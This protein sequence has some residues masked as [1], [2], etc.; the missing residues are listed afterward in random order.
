M[1]KIYKVLWNSSRNG[2]VVVDEA[3]HAHE[4]CFSSASGCSPSTHHHSLKL[5]IETLLAVSAFSI[6]GGLEAAGSEITSVQSWGTT[7]STNGNVHEI[8]TNKIVN[9]VVGVN[10]FEKFK[11]SKGDI[12]NLRFPDGTGHLVNFVDDKTVGIEING[13][14]NGVKGGKIDGDLY[15]VSPKGFVVGAT[16]VVNAKGLTVV[17]PTETEY[18]LI[19]GDV[20]GR[21][22][23]AG[24]NLLRK[25]QKA[26]GTNLPLNPHGV[27]TVQG[28][29]NAGNNLTLAAANISIPKD[30]VVQAG[31]TDFSDYVN[32]KDGS[33][34]KVNSGLD[35]QNLKLTEV[36]G[37]VVL[38]ASAETNLSDWNP[39]DI[40]ASEHS[41]R[42]AHITIGGEVSSKGKTG[43]VK[44]AAKA[45]NNDNLLGNISAKVKL[46]TGGKITASGDVSV[47][48]DASTNLKSNG[49][50]SGVTEYLFDFLGGQINLPLP[51]VAYSNLKTSALVD[52]D[53]G[54]VISA[55]KDV[56]LT[57]KATVK[58]KIGI[59]AADKGIYQS[60]ISEVVDQF[61]QTASVIGFSTQSSAVN[62]KGSISAG[63]D[64]SILS[65]GKFNLDLSAKGNSNK[66]SVAAT[67]FIYSDTSANSSVTVADTAILDLGSS[68]S[69]LDIQS[70]QT[71][72]VSTDS[73]VTYKSEKSATYGGIAFNYSVFNSASNV[74]LN[75]SP[76]VNGQEAA[77]K[78]INLSSDNTTSSW[79]VNSAVDSKWTWASTALVG[80]ADSAFKLEVMNK[81]LG[82]TNK[83]LV[84]ATAQEN[85]RG[86]VATT[87]ALGSQT[88]NV[89]VGNGVKLHSS[90]GI[91]LS[92]NAV[93]SDYVFSA[94][95]QS[96]ATEK[97]TKGL[98]AVSVVV[99]KP[100]FTD[101]N[102]ST[103]DSQV[104]IGE[105]VSLIADGKSYR[106]TVKEDEKEV[107]GEEK[108]G[109]RLQSSS[110]MEWDRFNSL[111]DELN[112]SWDIL[113]KQF[114]EKNDIYQK[115]LAFKTDT[116]TIRQN[117]AQVSGD[118][119]LSAW[120]KTKK[121]SES[122]KGML[123]YVKDLEGVYKAI[124]DIP[125]LT[126][127]TSLLESALAFIGAENYANIKSYAATIAPSTDG[128]S[129]AFDLALSAAYAQQRTASS[130]IVGNGTVIETKG[131]S[132]LALDSSSDN[133]QVGITGRLTTEFVNWID[134]NT[135]SKSIG[136]SVLIPVLETK[137]EIHLN[138][139][140]QIISDGDL[141]INAKDKVTAVSIA[142]GG[143]DTDNVLAINGMAV[144]SSVDASNRIVIDPGALLQ[145]NNIHIE[146]SRK[147]SI[148]TVAGAYSGSG[149]AAF[150]IGAAINM[151]G[152]VNE[153]QI[154]SKEEGKEKVKLVAAEGEDGL[155]VL[156]FSD[157][158]VNAVG[159][160]GALSTTNPSREETSGL[161]SILTTGGRSL[162]TVVNEKITS[163][164]AKKFAE[165]GKT[166]A[167]KLTHSQD[168]ASN[169]A[170]Q[171]ASN[172][173]AGLQNNGQ[174]L[175]QNQNQAQVNNQ[176]QQ[177][178][179]QFDL[180]GSVAWNDFRLANT[181]E[182]SSVILDS[183]KVSITAHDDKWIGAWAGAAALSIGKSDK[184]SHSVGIGGA[185]GVNQ[186]N[187]SNSVLL[188]N[189]EIKVGKTS[190]SARSKGTITAEGLALAVA[191]GGQ[192][193]SEVFDGSV[194]VNMI[195]QTT[196]VDADNIVL[197][198]DSSDAPDYEQTAWNGVTQVTG[199][200]SAGFSSSEGTSLAGGFSVAI[201]EI[202]NNVVSKL[203]NAKFESAGD[204]KIA[205]LVS[206][207]QITH[208]FTGQLAVGGDSTYAF[209]GAAGVGQLNNSV[210]AG[211][212]NSTI[213]G[214]SLKVESR[215]AENEEAKKLAQQGPE[216]SNASNA[217]SDYLEEQGIQREE[218]KSS[219][220]QAQE[221]L[222]DLKS[223]SGMTVKVGQEEGKTNE[224]GSV[225]T[226]KP[227]V[228]V[229]VG[230]DIGIGG[231]SGAA[232][233]VVNTI[234]N[235]YS[236]LMSGNTLTLSGG[237][238]AGAV[239]NVTSVGVAAGAAGGKGSFNAAGQVVVSNVTQNA[240]TTINNNVQISAGTVSL[241]SKNKAT[242][243]NVAGNAGLNFGEGVGLGAAVLVMNTNNTADILFKN[244]NKFSASALNAV[245]ANTSSSW[246]AA[247][248][249]S[250]TTGS[251]AIAGAVAVNRVRNTAR[252]TGETLK[253]SSLNS[254]TFDASDESVLWTLSGA[255]GGSAGT[256][257]IGGAV[258][259]AGFGQYGENGTIVRLNT[260]ELE[261][262][263]NSSST[264]LSI[265][266]QGKE[267]LNSL[268]LGV[269]VAAGTVGL[270]GA[271]SV[272][273]SSGKVQAV[274]DNLRGST[275][276]S[277][278]VQSKHDASLGNLSISAS[279][280]GTGA[281]GAGIAI[282]RIKNW[283]T[284]SSV[285]NAG[286]L[287]S[288]LTLNA[289]SISA[290]EHLAI[291]AIGVGGSG[292][293][294]GAL[295][296]S[297]SLNQINS[298]VSAG[299]FNSN[300]NSSSVALIEAVRDTD[301]ETYNVQGAGAGT[302]SGA[303]GVTYSEIKGNS[304]ADV[305]NS[306][307]K[308]ENGSTTR[309]SYS[310]KDAIENEEIVHGLLSKISA[311]DLGVQRKASELSGLAVH[312]DSTQ[313]FKTIFAAGSGSG[314]A[315]LTGTGSGITSQSNSAVNIEGS[316]LSSVKKA[317]VYAGNDSNV[318]AL[319]L[320]GS[321]AAT[322][323]AAATV[324]VLSF[325]NKASVGIKNS[326]MTGESMNIA[327]RVREGNSL[328]GIQ[329]AGATAAAGAVSVMVVRENS[330]SSVAVENSTLT[331][332]N[333][334]L[335][336]S[337]D[338][339]SFSAILGVSGA[340]AQGFG[341]AGDVYWVRGRN[342]SNLAISQGSVLNA[343]KNLEIKA[344]AEG[345]V[346]S[347]NVD[348]AGAEFAALAAGVT[349]TDLKTEASVSV[350]NSEATSVED[351]SITAETSNTTNLTRADAS[352]ALAA[353]GAAVVVENLNGNARVL[354]DHSQ[355]KA[356]KNLTIKALDDRS[357]N[358]GLG[359]GSGGLGVGTAAVFV[360][361]HGS[362]TPDF[363][364][365]ESARKRYE[366][367]KS[368]Y[369]DNIG[370]NGTLDFIQNAFNASNLG[371]AHISDSESDSIK[372]SL[373]S[374][375]KNI[376][377]Q[378][379]ASISV[380]SS[381]LSGQNIDLSAL[382]DSKEQSGTQ[383]IVGGIA[384][385]GITLG[386]S[387]G[388]IRDHNYAGISVTDSTLHATDTLKIKSE[389]DTKN[390]LKVFQGSGGVISAAAT[391]A[392]A[393]LDGQ[394]LIN[395]SGGAL[396]AS[397]TVASTVLNNSQTELESW[398]VQAGGITGGASIAYITDSTGL[399]SRIQ[400]AEIDALNANIQTIAARKLSAKAIA[401]YGGGV[402][403]VGSDSKITIAKPTGSALSSLLNLSGSI[404]NAQNLTVLNDEHS[405]FAV[406]SSGYGGTGIAIGVSL[407]KIEDSSALSTVVERNTINEASQVKVMTAA[408]KD[409]DEEAAS[410]DN[411]LKFSAEAV[412][413]G[414]AAVQSLNNSA[415]VVNTTSVSTTFQGNK[416]VPAEDAKT[417][418][419][420]TLQ[421]LSQA[422][423]NYEVKSLAG[424]GGAIAVGSGVSE[425]THGV[426]V[427]TTVSESVGTKLQDLNI[428]A[429]NEENVKGISESAGG[430]VLLIEG[431]GKS[432]DAARVVHTDKSDTQVSVNGNWQAADE[433]SIF[434][435][436]HHNLRFK[437]DNTKGAL[438]GG[439]GAAVVN[440]LSGISSVTVGDN[441][442]L[443]AGSDIW[444][445]AE[446]YLDIAATDGAYIVDSGVHGAFAGS[447]IHIDTDYNHSNSVVIGAGSQI[448]AAEVIRLQSYT[449]INADLK[450]LADSYGA[451]TGAT[452]AGNHKFTLNNTVDL[453]E[454]SSLKTTGISSEIV[455]S[456]SS[457]E[458]LH[459]ESIGKVAGALSGSG[460]SVNANVARTEL[461]TIGQGA[462]LDS[463]G[464]VR[465][466][467]GKDA[468]GSENKLDL[469][470][471]SHAYAY[472]AL[473]AASTKVEG[474]YV[475]TNKINV[476]GNVYAAR[477]IDAFASEGIV[478]S[479]ESAR[480]W[481]WTGTNQGDIKVATTEAG[482][483]LPDSFTLDNQI[484]VAGS[485][486]AGKNV[487][488]DI[489]ISGVVKKESDAFQ[490]LLNGAPVTSLVKPEITITG[491]GPE[492]ID[493]GFEQYSN[494]YWNRYAELQALIA[495]Y[496]STDSTA[497][498]AYT[499]EAQA[500]LQQ[501]LDKGFFEEKDGE[502]IPVASSEVGI[503][504]LAGLSISGGNVNLKSSHVVGNGT[505]AARGAKHINIENKSNLLLELQDIQI[506]D[507]GGVITYNN[508]TNADV[509]LPEFKGTKEYST[510][511]QAPEFRVTTSFNGKLQAQ[512]EILSEDTQSKTIHT[513]EVP[514]YSDVRIYGK[515]QNLSG[516]LSINSGGDI[517]VDA[518]SVVNAAGQVNLQATGNVTQSY[519]EG[520][521]SVGGSV[522]E[523]W[524]D[525]WET[526]KKTG[527][528]QSSA[529]EKPHS[530]SAGIHA[531]GDIFIAADMINVNGTVQSGYASYDLTLD[532]TS[533]KRISEIRD[534]W[535][536]QG[537]PDSIN[538]Y[539]DQYL[540]T[541]GLDFV[542]S[543]GNW[544]KNCKAWY[545]PVTDQIVL[546]DIS[547]KGGRIYLTGKIAN[548]GGGKLRA[549][550]GSVGIDINSGTHSILTGDINTGNLHGSIRIT[551]T[552]W[553]G[554]NKNGETVAAKVT[555]YSKSQGN[556]EYWLYKSG[557]TSEATAIAEGAYNPHE[558][559][560]YM[561]SD[562]A[563]ETKVKIEST[564][565]RFHIWGAWKKSSLSWTTEKEPTIKEL[566]ELKKGGT[567]GVLNAY[568]SG[569]NIFESWVTKY[570][571]YSN[572]SV[573]DWVEYDN[574]THFNGYYKARRTTKSGDLVVRQYA[575]KAD[576]PID[577]GFITTGQNSINLASSKNVSIGGILN[578]DGGTIT[579]NAGN[580]I[581]SDNARAQLSGAKEINLTAAGNIGSE[582]NAIKLT[583]KNDM[584]VRAVGDDIS[585]NASQVQGTLAGSIVGRGDVQ[586]LAQNT[587]NL[588]RFASQDAKLTSE[589]G[590]VNIHEL[591]QIPK[592]D[593][594]SRLDVNANKGQVSIT[595]KGD[596]GLGI[597]KA[598]KV[599]I[600]TDGA[601]L[602][603]LPRE[604]ADQVSLEEK[605][606][607]WK[608]AGILGSANSASEEAL[609]KAIVERITQQMKG[610]FERYAE[611]VEAE[612]ST[613]SAAQK[614]YRDSLGKKLSD[615]Y[616]RSGKKGED[617]K[618]DIEE[619]FKKYISAAE[620]NP[621]SELAR[622]KAPSYK[623]WTESELIYAVSDVITNPKA[624]DT[625]VLD[626]VANI[627]ADTV[628]LKAKS[629][630]QEV[631]P[632][633][634][635][636]S[637]LGG[638]QALNV[639]K[640]LAS[641]DAHDVKWDA[642]QGQ[643]TVGLKR[644]ISVEASNLTESL[645]K[646]HLDA[647]TTEGNVFVEAEDNSA[648]YV[649]KVISD[650]ANYEVRLSA[651]QGIYN[652]E[653]L[654]RSADSSLIKSSRVTLRGGIGSLGT[655]VARLNIELINPNDLNAYGSF[656]ASSGV[657]LNA[658]DGVSTNP[659]RVDAIASDKIVDISLN[660][661][662][663][664]MT[665]PSG[666]ESIASSYI[667]AQ[668]I[669]L[670]D[671]SKV[672]SDDNSIRLHSEKD[673][674]A[675]LTFVTDE[676][677]PVQPALLNIHDTGSGTLDVASAEGEYVGGSEEQSKRNGNLSLNG[678]IKL[679]G[680]GSVVS[681]N[682]ESKSGNVQVKVAN[683]AAVGNVSANNVELA[684]S[685]GAITAKEL[686]A[687]EGAV[688]ATAG[689]TLTTENVV[690]ANEANLTAMSTAQVGNVT[691][692]KSI[693][694]ASTDGS[695]TAGA[696]T[697]EEGSITAT[698]G[699]TLTTTGKVQSADLA[700]LTANDAVK[701]SDVRAKEIQLTSTKAD[702]TA[703]DLTST[704]G[705]IT[706]KSGTELKTGAL[707]SQGGSIIA[708]AGTSLTTTGKVNSAEAVT[709]TA[710]NDVVMDAAEAEGV[711]SVSSTSGNV[712]I[713]GNLVSN[714]GSIGISGAQKVQAADLHASK[715][716]GVTSETNGI[717]LG[718]LTSDTAGVTLNA[719]LFVKSQS[720][721]A[722][723]GKLGIGTGGELTLPAVTADSVD[724]KAKKVISKDNS[725]INIETR[726]DISVKAETIEAESVVLKSRE[727]NVTTT[728]FTENSSAKI[729][730]QKT[731]DI[732]A[733]KNAK[734]DLD[735][736]IDLTEDFKI[737]A[738]KIEG[739]QE[740]STISAGSVSIA[741]RSG[742]LALGT[743]KAN[744]SNVDVSLGSGNLSH[745]GTI[746]AEKGN[747]TLTASLNTFKDSNVSGNA[748]TI[749]G[750]VK[751]DSLNVKSTGQT[752]FGT[753]ALDMD[754]ALVVDAESISGLEKVEVTAGTIALT[755]EKD[756]ELNKLTAE[757]SSVL[758]NAKAANVVF[759]SDL[760]AK[761]G[762]TVNA[763]AVKMKDA[764][765]EINAGSNIDIKAQTLTA[766]GSLLL[767]STAGS[768]DMNV[769]QK[770]EVE[771][772]LTVKGQSGAT[773][774]ATALEAQSTF[775]GSDSGTALLKTNTLTSDS[776]NMT[777]TEGD[778]GFKVLS[779]EAKPNITIADSIDLKSGK[780]L[781]V[782]AL[783]QYDNLKLNK[784]L[785]L[786]AEKGELTGLNSSSTLT[787]DAGNV[788]ILAKTGA[789]TIAKVQA[790]GTVNVAVEELSIGEV[791]AK[792]KITLAGTKKVS[793]GQIT[794]TGDANGDILVK[795]S[796]GEVLA[797][798]T[799]QSKSGGV[800][801]VGKEK[802]E[803]TT[804]EASKDVSVTSDNNGIIVQKI[805]S[806]NGA[807]SLDSL[808]FI[809][810][811][812]ISAAQKASIT[813]E[814]S[815][816]LPS[817]EA[818][819]AY[820]KA[821]DISADHSV[822]IKTKGDIDV[823][824][825]SIHSKSIKL[826][827][828][829]G[830][831]SIEAADNWIVDGNVNISASGENA[832]V[833]VGSQK[834]FSVTGGAFNINTPNGAA[835]VYGNKGLTIDHDLAI[836]AGKDTTLF[837]ESGDLDIGS[838]SQI[839]AISTSGISKLNVQ[840]GGNLSIG[841]SA[842]L[843][844]NVINVSAQKDVS[845]GS[846]AF[847]HS[848]VDSNSPTESG[849][850]DIKSHTGN[851]TIADRFEI[852]ADNLTTITA[853]QGSVRI[854]NDADVYVSGDLSIKSGEDFV[855]GDDAFIATEKSSVI[856]DE[857]GRAKG[858]SDV[859]IVSG[860]N[861][862]FGEGAWIISEADISVVGGK[863]VK[864]GDEALLVAL[865]PSAEPT[866]G[867][868]T[869]RSTGGSV[870]LEGTAIIYGEE[871]VD[872]DAADK[873]TIGGDAYLASE[874]NVDVYAGEIH[875]D[876]TSEVLTTDGSVN[877]VSTGGII[878]ASDAS[879]K[880]PAGVSI[881]AAGRLVAQGTTEISS[882]KNV[883][884][885]GGEIR[886][887]GTSEIL[888]GNGSVEILSMGDLTL[889][890][891]AS[892]KGE[893]GVSISAEGRF[894][895][896]GTTEISSK[897]KVYIQGG[898][899]RVDGASEVVSEN[900][901]VRLKSLGDMTLAA[902]ASVKA[903]QEVVLLAD[904]NLVAQ[905]STKISS[906]NY[907][908]IAGGNLRFDSAS[909]VFSEN[910]GV[911]LDSLGDLTLAS[912]ASI[913]ARENVVLAANGLL[914]VQ[915]RADISSDSDI[916]LLGSNVTLAGGSEI[917]GS[918]VE[919]TAFAGDVR[920]QG[921]SWVYT[922][923][924]SGDV[925]IQASRDIRLLDQTRIGAWDEETDL[926][927][928]LVV[929]KAGNDV[930]QRQSKGDTGVTAERLEA[931]ANG[932]IVLGSVTKMGEAGEFGGNYIT[933]A[934]LEAG[935]DV[936]LA[937]TGFATTVYVNA[938][939]G[940]V[941]NGHV[942]IHGEE[943]A[944]NI[945]NS[946]SAKNEVMLHSAS[947]SG[948]SIVS[949][950]GIEISSSLYDK[951]GSAIEFDSVHGKSVG[952][953]S[954]NAEINIGSVFGQDYVDIYRR[955]NGVTG[956]IQVGNVGSNRS[957]MLY[958]GNGNIV[959]ETFQTPGMIAVTR[960]G[961]I[962]G[963]VLGKGVYV[964]ENGPDLYGFLNIKGVTGTY[965]ED[966]PFGVVPHFS[967]LVT[968][969]FG[970][971]RTHRGL[972]IR[973]KDVINRNG[974][975]SFLKWRQEDSDEE[976]YLPREL[977]EDNLV[978]INI[979]EGN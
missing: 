224:I 908:N 156:A 448:S 126:H 227:L 897:N 683:A 835:K 58:D 439:S 385:G 61:P 1:N 898:E 93:V 597:L 378:S 405:Q 384:I 425:I 922:T 593:G 307:I 340:G 520:I 511:S 362:Q 549:V 234:D 674:E 53:Q 55:Q 421:V 914:T 560:T 526:T 476:L 896:Q 86:V 749:S 54:A 961:S 66:E 777:S 954:G 350:E 933:E 720:I 798:G 825:T 75:S 185:V 887:D 278:D 49:H 902:D 313:T 697:S 584:L 481:R 858:R 429:I 552:A 783:N 546:D 815:L 10:R 547:P 216:S 590:S 197:T 705:S 776:L 64:L 301:V 865:T 583:S 750:E 78:Y 706:V 233:V 638:D 180:A 89:K 919:V 810:A 500:L 103:V 356:A 387:V 871:S 778:V 376:G 223:V 534:S 553:A 823:D 188:N 259:Y 87:F 929:L 20:G 183:Q 631:D 213:K 346:N 942:S 391:V 456:A 45:Q 704:G 673:G 342:L 286:N 540:L 230:M 101:D 934:V 864:F 471:Y 155:E 112:E 544:H 566:S 785:R 877:L 969:V 759:N 494:L 455:V 177:L 196:Q 959:A 657:Y 250:F 444:I 616:E 978:T 533:E 480:A 321:G 580:N 138:P 84:K 669:I 215:T 85:F 962:F 24:L 506:L 828:V 979:P 145:A 204:V 523:L 132:D 955:A 708:N 39:V 726:G 122:L 63:K 699:T 747:V 173:N 691:A 882:D 263:E 551:D 131:G 834:E 836:T 598:N 970:Q 715:D 218:G 225:V 507:K 567:I 775:I 734:V 612:D 688:T 114:T 925:R 295:Q 435:E 94:T 163:S 13:T 90:S 976:T 148:Q 531:G 229:T 819:S 452:A 639:Y 297:L 108:A 358:I 927:T 614:E 940:G 554:E 801:I 652:G 303:L 822:D 14:V 604:T 811:D 486:I 502:I 575:V 488:S 57:S 402:S 419:V 6:A 389:L 766:E 336:L 651:K 689:T 243:V 605:L 878:L 609:R 257:G 667:K 664:L 950:A 323:A 799:I 98:A 960:Q 530:A 262:G 522:E 619:Q 244:T 977:V 932:S 294:T 600:T 470:A 738:E 846:D 48:A 725:P 924:D 211:L 743:L 270:Q 714:E 195:D 535:I 579:I 125:S 4:G 71:N 76:T 806:A 724:L 249:G 953:L 660:G 788:E 410:D 532:A 412:S 192:R 31:V 133:T 884:I 186:A 199:G 973:M 67:S 284:L 781:D 711:I 310:G 110:A 769:E 813:T 905:G 19:E 956:N 79:L 493:L 144:A 105:G 912:D 96:W 763:G 368:K 275:L 306:T 399:N 946:I 489:V 496:K 327:S 247:V 632:V 740:N 182:M 380:V 191:T 474:H 565:K 153:V 872:L 68:D 254:A 859:S 516:N 418:I 713:S 599:E 874:K 577:V 640:T 266:A 678:D 3:H 564:S 394:A 795:S 504:T 840:S 302:A 226:G 59:S 868:L 271:A 248:D 141:G 696:L 782:S 760:S 338:L 904:G 422:V 698:A 621:D 206:G 2:H 190:V 515:I 260:I 692:T 719:P 972:V 656:S 721:S 102:I 906:D 839:H 957:V 746:S 231:K 576:Q 538:V 603:A 732:Q 149:G 296:A 680:E 784:D 733:K 582:Q 844:A 314:S 154:G 654:L 831:I 235:S 441:A 672:G 322:A 589:A 702:V 146:A 562:G 475:L 646:V 332:T 269:G 485:L 805:T 558:G 318:N 73:T 255:V 129:S 291:T 28:K 276:A 360:S 189:V 930:Y 375:N 794:S 824:A 140:V 803:A 668:E 869:V 383:G 46:E 443:K 299:L 23:Q 43:N 849:T 860:G 30:A 51:K 328:F 894:A 329:G 710:Q 373:T 152:F 37:E 210:S 175:A 159:V 374:D 169:A 428:G 915:G 541:D 503:L 964:L 752:K 761:D 586:L 508:K 220:D 568:P 40:G 870:L 52:I 256:G 757:K 648:L 585:L 150:G 505:I 121:V 124:K 512:G 509:L 25:G 205:A 282:N 171:N 83:D 184:T 857:K 490:L 395:I 608:E 417:K 965:A 354:I 875:L 939:Q 686:T 344:L 885:Q 895:T 971:D 424:E 543:D 7:I 279:A 888:S 473:P 460:A 408:G 649:G 379:G 881:S 151:D 731:V 514:V 845:L 709:L 106:P 80:A 479:K 363:L 123:K 866:E 596:L 253:L 856:A 407:A 245:S 437:A 401:G 893:A 826:S 457:T 333:G 65:E 464:Y 768:A 36:D 446:D 671:A 445:G 751:G 320:T 937:L 398:G 880:G 272:L 423:A 100:S 355:I 431:T 283:Q 77:L 134:V 41:K 556:K 765:A 300:I 767:S 118:N 498:I 465:L 451:V 433:V 386:A 178:K 642:D 559:L 595:A 525:E 414:G 524:K 331:T 841:E 694:L 298:D 365:D 797:A 12:A 945:G 357:T 818:D 265:S 528:G 372:K 588:E 319:Y 462:L 745:A 790:A 447:G 427:A 693:Q 789:Q 615:S 666:S 635:Q 403:G 38:L 675:L 832:K 718:T 330:T 222:S 240:L 633:T 886:V 630:G 351:V 367:A 916:D 194:S 935:K 277:L 179:M 287:T 17:V 842:D 802:V 629:I 349:G 941:V 353:I 748:V 613:L 737:S 467:S 793:V 519:H 773:V 495:E 938:S 18:N 755:S 851:V 416:F 744:E 910:G 647:N 658:A 829:G 873:L 779:E 833:E 501:M 11:V 92:S 268:T 529:K 974:E 645:G 807:V 665:E 478:N 622:A 364:T 573:E 426:N 62:V 33:N 690:A 436:S 477:E 920:M 158:A 361:T 889:A 239:N 610:E 923:D 679:S 892:V 212:E 200:T 497:L 917:K 304:H 369:I 687:K 499:T 21:L 771:K 273:E 838:N 607:S 214:K 187:I 34:I 312:A 736:E 458:N 172:N 203:K 786:S 261:Q 975:F 700:E 434:A 415:S 347:I 517:Y 170:N 952:I 663:L 135:K 147:D 264:A 947:V 316:T 968:E 890:S 487:S 47:T 754:S 491:E 602:D 292:A 928:H 931:T 91:D 572:T 193:G 88:S 409:S 703:G 308:V 15:F 326:A 207:N 72:D 682:L 626:G 70:K 685:S 848:I 99:A 400:N 116:E 413:Y 636:F 162:I 208:A 867:N 459:L 274:I 466:Y 492:V 388:I 624:S 305:K 684:S 315:S 201:S 949:K 581:L 117:L 623:V 780:N 166:A 160:A 128:T 594:T 142:V 601:L 521:L 359:S 450:V 174:N 119:T 181:V 449:D 518:Q 876:G 958:N 561:W 167:Q 258:S 650:K 95:G 9:E 911:V 571:E 948:S 967:S 392:D 901:E 130:I 366:E 742:D 716:I 69:I 293:G 161:Q 891:D 550:D 35:P 143:S 625:R 879:V 628:V 637:D 587:I 317:D 796:E 442:I 406:K 853:E 440:T 921:N 843:Y 820:V 756:L 774:S 951:E 289:L 830:N 548:T 758:V 852:G 611:L 936:N 165:W 847:I 817:L 454:K 787:I 74:E 741:A 620:T 236:S 804:I 420:P 617:L 32:I 855:I 772:E 570:N 812:S 557:K 285:G 670:R 527:V 918:N 411:I 903:P 137:N 97:G 569:N 883:N 472:S 701:V 510:D 404:I 791:E 377:A 899:I 104:F 655:S 217:A 909:E 591:T 176:P 311:K 907:V 484:S 335:A 539:S 641:A 814:G 727:E 634:Y 563:Q 309:K 115:L 730:A 111:V 606:Q 926:S 352:G 762:I 854:G 707:T 228:Q 644:S 81:I 862:V 382:Q 723:K 281:G 232:G 82:L 56:S 677:S 42:E 482:E 339:S 120:G 469:L 913:T 139:N 659:F 513:V 29:I 16:G 900:G 545:N 168:Q 50:L 397:N 430:A 863:D 712:S 676:T 251:V 381:N 816:K 966:V 136:G 5:V 280:A 461:V 432:W 592:V 536:A 808:S 198:S 555:E 127:L 827:S 246:A 8:T 850:V 861:A 164:F 574:W 681:G 770:V 334:D 643:I 578:A 157:T 735:G 113:L 343:A 438:A 728:G 22:N 821:K 695:V 537:S 202:N 483:V 618:A 837:T 267:K 809:N 661:K 237:L 219:S 739:I 242:T 107:L 627:V 324:N 729:T 26:E 370:S 27:V 238:S 722:A 800:S 653:S 348:A 252:V 393:A 943:N 662:A 221:V 963:P 337:S 325:E 764:E 396:K 341:A 542:G 390:K 60:P 792:E 944:L 753:T 109:I 371:S 453:K 209:A 288:P 463:N 717:E 241:D 44:I 468:Y 345:K 290:R